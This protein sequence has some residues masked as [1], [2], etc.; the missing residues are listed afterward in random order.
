M[1]LYDLAENT[2]KKIEQYVVEDDENDMLAVSISFVKDHSRKI[3][4]LEHESKERNKM[5]LEE[6]IK[7][8]KLKNYVVI[9]FV[10]F[11]FGEIS[12]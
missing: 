12:K 6:A 10:H 2:V 7:R 5:S 4:D 1:N 11:Y 8:F 9:K 3:Y